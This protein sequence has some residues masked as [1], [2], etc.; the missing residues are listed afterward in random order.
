MWTGNTLRRYCSRELQKS[1]S[2]LEF[3]LWILLFLY[4][5]EW[6]ELNPFFVLSLIHTLYLFFPQLLILFPLFTL[7]SSF[8]DSSWDYSIWKTKWK[9][10]SVLQ[11]C[12]AI[13]SH[14]LACKVYYVLLILYFCFLLRVWDNLL[15]SLLHCLWTRSGTAAL[16]WTISQVPH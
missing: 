1:C 7:S 3:L 5:A 9:I 13:C 2:S 12:Y 11:K 14:T 6:F 4:V 10:P 8:L 15:K 16:F